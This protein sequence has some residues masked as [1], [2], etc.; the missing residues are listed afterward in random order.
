MYSGRSDADVQKFQKRLM[1]LGYLSGVSGT[2]DSN[3]VKAVKQVQSAL[4][5]R[6]N[7]GIA[8]R[9]LQAFLYKMGDVIKK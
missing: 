6:D 1:E 2:Y 7:S 3:T 5:L 9:E 8:T 4:G